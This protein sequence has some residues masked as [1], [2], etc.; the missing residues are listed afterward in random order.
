MAKVKSTTLVE[1]NREIYARVQEFS[2]L[3]GRPVAD[4]T[5]EAVGYWLDTLGECETEELI[6]GSVDPDKGRHN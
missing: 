3:H 1:I 2:V 4:I 5:T 6:G